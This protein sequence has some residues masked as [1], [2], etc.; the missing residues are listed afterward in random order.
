MKICKYSFFAA[1]I[2]FT[3]GTDGELTAQSFTLEKLEKAALTGP[4]GKPARLELD[5]SGKLQALV[6]LSPECPFSANYT[7][8]LNRLAEKYGEQVQFNGI[9]PG[10]M[11]TPENVM[12]FVSEYGIGFK[13]YIDA[14]KRLPDY[15]KATVTPEVFLLGPEGG[16][17]YSGAIDNWAVSLG[18]TRQV[19]T[20]HYLQDAIDRFLSGK[21]ILVRHTQAVGCL[22]NMF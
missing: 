20:E 21:S 14:G 6:F 2:L 12:K 8:T 16:L 11:Y 4:T 7:L 5:R 10:E 22:I 19:I 9:V 1:M 15:L 13:V 17:V 18:K 3:A